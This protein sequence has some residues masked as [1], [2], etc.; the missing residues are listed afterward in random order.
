MVYTVIKQLYFRT[1]M[2]HVSMIKFVCKSEPIR[3]HSTL[4]EYEIHLLIYTDITMHVLK[5]LKEKIH[6]KN[7]NTDL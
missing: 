1:S 4:I 2:K 7:L 6:L 5:I 3:N